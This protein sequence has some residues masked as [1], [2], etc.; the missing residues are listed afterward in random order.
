M[1][2][3]SYL[4][5]T[6]TSEELSGKFRHDI[7]RLWKA[8]KRKLPSEDLGQFDGLIDQLSRLERIRYPDRVIE[9]GAMMSMGWS[10]GPISVSG[11]GVERVPA[12]ILSVNEI[13]ALVAKIFQVTSRNPAFYTCML[14]QYGREALSYQNPYADYLLGV[15]PTP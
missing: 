9:E 5:R 1:L 8:F 12:Y 13:D 6:L 2:L 15:N 14:N 7:K 11:T 3:K 10:A 4:A